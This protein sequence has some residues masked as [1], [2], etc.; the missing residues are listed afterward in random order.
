MIRTM[1][2]M[3]IF[4]AALLAALALDCAAAP[5]S[6]NLGDTRVVLDA[7]PGFAD[8]GFTGSPRLAELAES[9]TSASNRILMFA[10][11]D[12]DLRRFMQGDQPEF[13]RYMTAVTPRGMEFE[14]VGAEAFRHYVGDSL[15]ELGAAPPPGDIAKHLDAQPPGKLNLLAELRKDP[16]VVT[17]LQGTRLPSQER[18]T[19]WGG[20]FGTEKQRYAITTT[21]LMLVRGK[22][23][24]FSVYSLY[25]SADD[26]Q[27]IRTI[28]ERWIDEVRRLNSR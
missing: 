6:V 21:T 17:V 4:A 3:R 20:V 28:T 7:P 8:T 2:A 24:N 5:F 18:G 13:R 22:A 9:I 12:A 19:T 26:M 11:T 23:L 14:R 16:E 10:I 27:W 1:T 15:S 25:E